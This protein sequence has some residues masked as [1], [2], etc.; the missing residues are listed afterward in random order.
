M[1]HDPRHTHHD[2]ETHHEREVHVVERDPGSGLGLVLGVLLALILA[3]VLLWFLFSANLF[4]AG[5]GT[6]SPAQP[7]D[8][9]SIDININDQTQPG[10]APA[11]PA[12]P[13]ANPAPDSGG[14]GTGTR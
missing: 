2:V 11:A 5:P 9:P 8:N 14:T 12:A 10:S 3:A 13:P 1:A 6:T 7:A 4:T